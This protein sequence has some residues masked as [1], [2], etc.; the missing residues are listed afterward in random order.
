MPL[1]EIIALEGVDLD[2]RI[3]E[4]LIPVLRGVDLQ[5]R[6]G[7]ILLVQGELGAGKSALINLLAGLEAP[8]RGRLRLGGIEITGPEAAAARPAIAAFVGFFGPWFRLEA[9][10]CLHDLVRDRRHAPR[11]DP[12][13]VFAVL[14][15]DPDDRRPFG[16]LDAP[17]RRRVDCARVM[18]RRPRLLVADLVAPPWGS[19]PELDDL[20]RIH[21]EFGITV[22]A[23]IDHDRRVEGAQ[24][25]RLESGRLV[26]RSACA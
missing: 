1:P 25:A 23:A 10:A 15:L 21:E 26:A 6:E 4:H 16:S 2:Y 24:L 17:T 5:V 13:Q 22:V 7:E 18:L 8:T 20:L 19:P 14:G 3:D 12:A 11:L 9:S